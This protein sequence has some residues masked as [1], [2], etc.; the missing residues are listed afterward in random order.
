MRRVFSILLVILLAVCSAPAVAMDFSISKMSGGLRVVVGSGTIQSGDA[1][2]LTRALGRAGRDEQGTKQL[3]LNSAGG[4]VLEALKMAD[5]MSRVG[6]STIVPKGSVCASACASVVFVAGKY[7]RLDRGGS[8]AI[9]SCYDSRTGSAVSE[10]NAIISARAQAGGVS[11]LALMALQ[12]AAGSRSIVVLDTDD[13]A[14]FGLTLK[15]GARARKVPPCL[16][17]ALEA[18]GRR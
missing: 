12:E 2:K 1:R 9:H 6:V 7:R 3:L 17:E 5:V 15:P 11:G 13:A 8:L 10:C 18:E 16:A 14:C 4:M